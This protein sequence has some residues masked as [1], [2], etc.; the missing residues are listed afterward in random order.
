MI[1]VESRLKIDERLDEMISNAQKLIE[2]TKVYEGSEE[3]QIRNLLEIAISADSFKA[4]EVFVRYQVGREKLPKL[5]ADGLL[6]EL[7]KLER[8]ANEIA[9]AKPHKEIWLEMNR[10]FLGYMA[11]WFIYKRKEWESRTKGEES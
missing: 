2:N 10:Q 11:R 8:I 4:L 9:K 6:A 3:A 1:D 7:T 5:F